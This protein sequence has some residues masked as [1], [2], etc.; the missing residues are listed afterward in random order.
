[1]YARDVYTLYGEATF[2]ANDTV[3]DLGCNEGLFTILAAKCGA[4]VLAVDAQA[5]FRA[6]L[7]D[8]LK[9][10]NCEQN[11]IFETR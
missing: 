2:G 7:L 9:R 6:E 10:N 3:I 5:G 4:R 8:H 11:V 1:M